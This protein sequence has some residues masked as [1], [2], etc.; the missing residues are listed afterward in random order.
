MNCSIE[1]RKI[2]HYRGQEDPVVWAHNKG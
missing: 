1:F 2:Q